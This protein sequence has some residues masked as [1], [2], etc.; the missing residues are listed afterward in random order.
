MATA[1]APHDLAICQQCCNKALWPAQGLIKR[2]GAIDDVVHTCQ[3][4]GTA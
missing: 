1:L 4:S 2:F 3:A